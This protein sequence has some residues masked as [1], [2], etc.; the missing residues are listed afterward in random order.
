M[1]SPSVTTLAVQRQLA[2]TSSDW[3]GTVFGVLLVGSLAATL[4]ILIAILV[5][6]VVQGWPVYATRGLDFLTSSLSANPANAGIGQ[7]IVGTILM[8]ILVAIICFP[9][10]DL[11]KRRRLH[12]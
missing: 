5:T 8:G 6:Q 11:R 7:G 10:M 9:L 4:F 12:R 2:G 1:S 3:R